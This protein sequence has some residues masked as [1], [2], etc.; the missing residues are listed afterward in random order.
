MIAYLVTEIEVSGRAVSGQD[1]R[2]LK[3]W[4]HNQGAGCSSEFGRVCGWILSSAPRWHV[5][6]CAGR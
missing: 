6:D 2:Q 1:L 5:P 3:K 4:A